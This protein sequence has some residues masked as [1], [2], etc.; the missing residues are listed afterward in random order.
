MNFSV[1]KKLFLLVIAGFSLAT[2]NAQI[3]FG[4]KAG[5]NFSNFSGSGVDGQGLSTSVGLNA[6]A[7]VKIPINEM[8]AVQP[9]LVYSGQGAKGTVSGQDYTLHA[10]YLNIPIL[11]KYSTSSGFFVQTGPQIGFLM[12]AKAS[13]GGSS[14]DDK[15]DY[16]ST[17]FSW[18][19][20][21]GYQTSSN[22]GIDARYN[23]GLSNIATDATNSSG[24]GSGTVKNGVF[25]ISLF[26][27]FG[28]MD[29]K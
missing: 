4:I 6:G 27:M 9:E 17:D 5:A 19:I 29:K 14:Q 21:A 1:H 25:Q 15:S 7:L 3:Q 28:M 11:L 8:F 10:N 26:Y 2:V 13:A 22:I 20:G 23:I 16:K 24:T 12:S 18:A